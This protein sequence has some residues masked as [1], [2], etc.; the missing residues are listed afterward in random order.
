MASGLM[1][2]LHLTKYEGYPMLVKGRVVKEV[3]KVVHRDQKDPET[4]VERFRDRSVTTIAAL[5][6]KSL[7]IIQDVDKLTRFMRAHGDK[8]AAHTL[9]TYQPLYDLKP[10][11][12]ELEVLDRAHFSIG[13]NGQPQLSLRGKILVEFCLS[14]KINHN[15]SLTGSREFYLIAIALFYRWGVPDLI[16]NSPIVKDQLKFVAARY[17]HPRHS[18]F[19]RMIMDGSISGEHIIGAAHF[20]NN[21]FVCC[22]RAPVV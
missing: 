6:A 4:I 16:M 14:L 2:T 11:D 22:P 8:I 10:K 17:Y 1:G 3:N 15:V 20:F 12:D 9:A 5:S 18:F 13:K 7:E 21:G 19:I